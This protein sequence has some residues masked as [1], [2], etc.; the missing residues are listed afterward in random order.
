VERLVGVVVLPDERTDGFLRGLSRAIPGNTVLLGSQD[1][2]GSLPPHPHLS[3]YHLVADMRELKQLWRAVAV[4]FRTTQQQTCSYVYKTSRGWWFVETPRTRELLKLQRYTCHAGSWFRHGRKVPIS[5]KNSF[6]PAQSA[7]YERWGYPN[8][9]SS[10]QPHFTIGLTDPGDEH[11]ERLRW[12]W[13]PARI[14]LVELGKH[15][16]A[17]EIIESVRM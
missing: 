8:V 6:S 16:T 15:G 4:T 10:W 12:V 5:W 17:V 11:R 2:G 9:R 1:A 3:L 7:A 13:T 14:A